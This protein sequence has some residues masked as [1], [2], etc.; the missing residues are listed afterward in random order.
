MKHFR[1]PRRL[2]PL[3]RRLESVVDRLPHWAAPVKR[4][5]DR[6][7]YTTTVEVIDP[8]ISDS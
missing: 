3:A 4:T 1:G 8:R 5:V 6:W 7:M 2:L